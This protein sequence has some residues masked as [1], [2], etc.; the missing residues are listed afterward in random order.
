MSENGPREGT[1]D[2]PRPGA[3]AGRRAVDERSAAHAV[4]RSLARRAAQRRDDLVALLRSGLTPER[5]AAR[6]T[7][8]H[9]LEPEAT[10]SEVTALQG[11]NGTRGRRVSVPD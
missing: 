3:E 8:D 6:Y 4:Y 5:A 10:V 11:S 1:R 9:P 2:L 7:R